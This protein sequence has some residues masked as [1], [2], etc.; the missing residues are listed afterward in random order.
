MSLIGGVIRGFIFVQEAKHLTTAVMQDDFP[1]FEFSDGRFSMDSNKP[2]IVELD[3]DVRFIIDVSGSYTIN[4]LV[5]YS[6]GY[7]LTDKRLT[8]AMKGQAPAYYDLGLFQGLHFNNS[9]L[10]DQLKLLSKIGL[11]AVPVVYIII[12]FITI[13]F[14]VLLL[15][16]FGLMMKKILSIQT[17]RGSGIF[18]MTLYAITLGIILTELYSL[19]SLFI[20]IP[21]IGSLLIIAGPM[22]LFFLPSATIMARG[23]R[24]YK[25]NENRID[26]DS[27]S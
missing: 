8:I 3:N 6:A 24:L 25:I 11:Y 27:L 22:L 16:L 12:R 4:D 1:K 13:L 5:G 14:R 9:I 17:L 10:L 20:V 26:K 15:V 21:I 23:M 19:I 18:K 7:L 2:I